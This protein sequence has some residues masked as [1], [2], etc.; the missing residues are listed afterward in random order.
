MMIAVAAAD[1]SACVKLRQAGAAEVDMSPKTASIAAAFQA[2]DFVEVARHIAAGD[3][4]NCRLFRGQGVQ[5]TSSGTPLHA[6]CAMHGLA[7]S[8]EIAQLL[9]RKGA[10]LAAG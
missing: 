4:V 1:E 5:A 7:G 8:T 2:R 10:D 9:I 3:D 6:C